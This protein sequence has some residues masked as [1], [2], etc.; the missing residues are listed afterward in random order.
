MTGRTLRDGIM[1]RGK[2]WSYVVR[3]PDPGTGGTRPRWVGSFTSEAEA[4]A[5]RDAARVA[6][7]QGA[8]VTRSR[9]TVADYFNAW[10][11]AHS[12]AVRPKSAAGYREDL[13][14]VLPLI[15]GMRLQDVRPSTLS[16]LYKHLLDS[17]GRGGRSLSP[18]TVEHVHRTLR[19]GFADAVNVDELLT[20]N[21][22]LRARRPYTL[23]PE[24]GR[25]WD[26][27]QLVSFLASTREHPLGVFFRLAAYTGARRGELLAL[28]WEDVDLPGAQLTFGRSVDV[29]DRVR[30]EGPTKGGRSRTISID[31][32]TVDALRG[33]LAR[34]RQRRGELGAAWAGDSSHVFVNDWGAPPFPDTVSALMAR[35]VRNAGLP[36]A[37]LHDLRHLHATTLLLAGVPVHVVAARLGHRDPAITLRV[38]A[39]VLGEQA[40]GVADVFA[41]A[42]RQARAAPA[43]GLADPPP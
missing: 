4:K 42:L 7:R 9:V 36:P 19:K 2:T 6:A 27:A 23:K 22:A 5:G 17:G 10:L 30:V 21:P 12:V 15:G 41:A 39:H 20:S 34:Q 28:R 35:L 43:P 26:T 37:R 29:I 31:G 8:Y 38:Y 11:E 16:R 14:R 18:A 3:V 40:A 25:I 33:H 1:K 13:A 32:G 24:P